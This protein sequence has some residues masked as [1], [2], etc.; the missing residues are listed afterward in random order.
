MPSLSMV[1][2]VRCSSIMSNTSSLMFTLPC[3]TTKETAYIRLQLSTTQP[4]RTAGTTTLVRN[5][6]VAIAKA[7]SVEDANINDFFHLCAESSAFDLLR[8][9]E[10]IHGLTLGEVMGSSSLWLNLARQNKF[11][12]NPTFNSFVEKNNFEELYKKRLLEV[13]DLLGLSDLEHIVHHRT[14]GQMQEWNF[15]NFSQYFYEKSMME[16]CGISNML[17]IEK[18]FRRNYVIRRC[19]SHDHID[20]IN[21]LRC[22]HILGEILNMN[23]DMSIKH[24]A[25][26]GRVS[27]LDMLL[28]LNML[29]QSIYQDKE[30][31]VRRKMI[32]SKSAKFGYMFV[33]NQFTW[34]LPVSHCVHM[35]EEIGFTNREVGQLV[36]MLENKKV[37]L[38]S[39]INKNM[40]VFDMNRDRFV[41]VMKKRLYI[42]RKESGKLGIANVL[43]TFRFLFNWEKVVSIIDMTEMANNKCFLWFGKRGNQIRVQFHPVKTRVMSA[44]RIYLME[45]FGIQEQDKDATNEFNKLFSRIPHSKDVPLRIVVESVMYLE[46]L[47][48]SK[49]QIEKGFPVVFYSKSILSLYIPKLDVVVGHDWLKKENVL[50][51]LNYF[52]EVEHKFSFDL[53]YS[54]IIN[55]YEGGMSDEFFS[56]LA[57]QAEAQNQDTDTDSAGQVSPHGSQSDQIS[58]HEPQQGHVSPHHQTQSGTLLSPQRV[59]TRISSRSLHT[60][61]TMFDKDK[62]QEVSKKVKVFHLQNP[63]TWLQIFIKFNE[64]KQRWDPSLNQREFLEGAVHAVHAVTDKVEGGQWQELRGLLSRKEFKRLRKEVETEWSD[65]M[66]RNVRL[67]V[68][69]VVK[70]VITGIT[71][72]QIVEN[73]Y[74]DI[75]V[76]LV[77]V[78]EDQDKAPIVV[79]VQMRL[80]REY[81]EGCLPDWMVTRFKIENWD[82][83]K[84]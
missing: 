52:I 15:A 75:D 64:V 18:Y 35:L 3:L 10:V 22:Y 6:L 24:L 4:P 49:E 27:A 58:P 45:Y 38:V 40:K 1:R 17:E 74:C 79:N 46:S 63:F 60:S 50:C 54:G 59:T 84:S 39:E 34:A 53:I 19:K 13:M 41:D 26:L 62:Q 71:T 11:K 77:G 69:Q 78:K 42:L 56:T 55:A 21:F 20:P 70:A 7:Y 9:P 48:L 37:G 14:E 68:D 12:F 66:R 65:V 82:R 23:I 43:H 16:L 72:Q 33:E 80:H 81:T 67:E 29:G 32:V 8:C 47:G 57:A 73:K 44:S 31:A 28:T 36:L 5:R 83:R 61:P 30:E 2:L 51:L 76:R 25:L